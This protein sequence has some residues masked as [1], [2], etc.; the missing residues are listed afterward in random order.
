MQP[1]RIARELALIALPQLPKK[2]TKLESQSLADWLTA[3]I[4]V[5]ADET[6][7]QLTQAA[8]HVQRSDH[9]LHDSTQILPS[10]QPL[11]TE[12]HEAAPTSLSTAS[13][14][15]TPQPS[16]PPSST[17][18]PSDLDSTAAT[19][20]R[21]SQLQKQIQRLETAIRTSKP[22]PQVQSELLG[23]SNQLKTTLA[24]A[25][26]QL[27]QS[28]QRLQTAREI[29]SDAVQSTQQAI[30]QVG[31]ALRLPEFLYLA[32]TTEVKAYALQIL[33]TLHLH[34]GDIDQ[35]IQAALIGWQLAR[36]SRIDRD[37]LR[38]AVVEMQF[39][40]SVPERVAINEAIELAKTYGNEESPTFLNAVLRR[41]LDQQRSKQVRRPTE[42]LDHA[43]TLPSDSNEMGSSPKEMIP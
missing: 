34:K 22:H 42:H 19:L 32:N 24:N 43:P 36:L 41:V 9:L 40:R 5:L 18:D 28:Q 26:Q 16:T 29:L 27:T 2:S 37:I 20:A 12:V 6:N 1:R 31:S 35:I 30:N 33:T 4:R 23:L 17:Q 8:S 13:P 11:K 15:H 39:L 7:D 14:D 3:A 21:L 25:T 38:I 10:P